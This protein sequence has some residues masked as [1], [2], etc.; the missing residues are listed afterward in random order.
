[1]KLKNKR[2]IVIPSAIVIYTIVIAIYAG[3]KYYTPE[4]KSSYFL[5]IGVNLL[6]AVLLYFLLKKREDLRKK[7]KK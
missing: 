2:H 4:N 7:N 1:M 6:L 5:V 3:V